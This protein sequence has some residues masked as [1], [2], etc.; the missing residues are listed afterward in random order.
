MQR[1]DWLNAALAALVEG[2][3]KA[4]AIERL[5]ENLGLTRGS[6]YHH[7]KDRQD[8]LQELL[9]YWEQRWTVEIGIEITAL[10]LDP[11]QSLLALVRMIR[12]RKASQYDAVFRSWALHDAMARQ[13]VERVDEYRLGVIRDLFERAGFEGLDAENRA[14]LLLYYEAAEPTLFAKQN[15]ETRDQLVEY[16]L[17]LL[18]AAGPDSD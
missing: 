15:R 2:G 17:K 13:V 11:R 9:T 7:F 10:G 14:R 8:L 18:T 4:I 5:A 12:H 1:R 16:R 3:I 6:F